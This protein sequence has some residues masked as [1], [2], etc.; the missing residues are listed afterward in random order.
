VTGEAPKLANHL[1]VLGKESVLITRVNSVAG[2][3]LK[4]S[5]TF[6]PRLFERAGTW[7]SLLG[8]NCVTKPLSKR[9]DVYLRTLLIHGARSAILVARRHNDIDAI[10]IPFDQPSID[11]DQL[12]PARFL[13]LPRSL[14]VAAM[15]HDLRYDSEGKTR[16]E[17]VF[18]QKLFEGARIVVAARNFGCG[19]SREAAVT[20]MIDNGFRAFIA[21]SFGDIFYS[22]CFQNGSLP[23]RLDAA[24]VA[25][26]R[27]GLH[28]APGAHIT[29]DLPSQIVIGPDGKRDAFE[30]DSFRKECLL[31]G[32]D[33]ISLTLE[34]ENAIAAFERRRS[35]EISWL[36]PHRVAE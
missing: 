10:A 14:Q 26:L 15:F 12:I 8:L 21:A 19:S 2:N 29:I 28:A 30:I 20:V 24:R 17:F 7:G 13:N 34:H 31:K 16:P 11:T 6:V 25:A 4:D 22:N 35:K 1:T 33:E 23:I 18:N 27:A 32:I 36:G 9:G 3:K 5:L